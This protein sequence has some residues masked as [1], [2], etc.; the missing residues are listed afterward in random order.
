MLNNYKILTVTHHDVSVDNI[1][2]YMF[3]C[4]SK[5]ELQ[6][7]LKAL[8]ANQEL[9]EL[10]YL[11]TCNRVMYFFKT[12]ATVDAHFQYNFLKQINP[13]LNADQI[14]RTV[15]YHEGSEALRHLFAVAASTNSMV[16]GERQILRQLREA[17]E[18]SKEFGLTGDCIR[19]AVD[20][21]VVASKDVYSNTKIGEKPVSVASIASQELLKYQL[22]KDARI[23]L[24]GAGQTNV[25]V[26]KFLEKYN[27]SNVTIFNRTV[28]KAQA[29]ADTFGGQAFPLSE[30]EFYQEGF[31]CLIV[32]T[33]ATE[34]IITSRI[35]RKLLNGDER[36]KLVIDIA[37]PNNVDRA[38]RETFDMQYVEVEDIRNL[39][40]QNMAFRAAEVHKAHKIIDRYVDEFHAVY[41][42]RKIERAMSSVPAE[43]KA[44]K[45]H[46]MNN[47][48]KDEIDELDE[49]AKAVLDKVLS[50]MEKRC[51]GIPMKAAREA[52]VSL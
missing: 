35:Y 37:I 52:A 17:Y 21:A 51:I 43:I 48:F 49:S 24:V 28:E 4:Q 30:L 25:L 36:K 16:I 3:K 19:L 40:N 50:Y 22:P 33:G 20:N 5:E 12:S 1:G 18:E 31:D 44:I 23:V 32:C 26:S 45:S 9:E 13:N 15:Q 29:I 11:S 8:Q 27:Y 46:A 47:L 10:L 39:A 38:V 14:E 2:S 7:K 34:A 41:Q 6:Y 42:Q